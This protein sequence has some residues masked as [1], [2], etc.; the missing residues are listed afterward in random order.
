M[1]TR[2]LFALPLVAT[3]VL[4]G[5]TETGQ[6]SDPNSKTQQGAIAGALVGGII[7]LSQDDGKLGKAAAGAAIGG[8][9]GAGIG[10]LLDKQA[11]DLRQDLGNDD[12]TI[13]NTGSE[14][15]VT[16]PQD[17]LFA[18]DSAVVRSGLQSDL[19]AL[20]R[21]LQDY[22]STTVEVVGHTDNTG[23]ASYNQDLSARRAASV[24]TILT[25]NGV[26][27]YRIKS[28]GRGEDAPIA[29]NLNAEGRAQN[30]RVEI[31]I[32]PSA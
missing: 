4:A 11:A 5:C 13:V 18:T 27:S 16:L 29:T 8:A 2:T 26:A 17:I 19:G 12:V 22:P 30:R 14:L 23:S 28:Y 1:K 32:S 20:A 21:N 25:A 3:V 10:S 6:M 31:I 9:L 7:G 24:S 15:I